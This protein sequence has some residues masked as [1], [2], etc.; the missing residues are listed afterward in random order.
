MGTLEILV[1]A[2]EW[3]TREL[4]RADLSTNIEGH[5]HELFGAFRS[6]VSPANVGASVVR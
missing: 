6:S 3:A 5:G 2:S 1:D 4:A